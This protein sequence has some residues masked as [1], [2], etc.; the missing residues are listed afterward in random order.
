V[1]G[2]E[3]DVP[4]ASAERFRRWLTDPDSFDV[5]QPRPAASIMLLRDTSNGLEVFIL[6][7]V[8]GMKFLPTATVFPGGGV[9]ARD[10][11]DLPWAGPSPA[12]WAR[13]MGCD[14]LTAR[15]LIATAVRE[16]FEEVGVLLA[17]PSSNEL[18]TGSVAEQWGPERAALESHDISLTE[19]LTAQNLV[20]R[21]D[22]LAFRSR[23]ITP[24]TEPSRFNTHFF[25]AA[26]PPG[27]VAEALTTEAD[28]FRWTDPQWPIDEARAGRQLVVAPTEANLEELVT[29]GNVAAAMRVP[30]HIE[31]IMMEP[32][33]RPDGNVGM[34]A[35][36]PY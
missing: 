5:V 18:V 10:N 7:R 16:L 31:P 29:A 1:I 34:R 36:R 12:E 19:F 23:W 8:T 33:W 15:Q 13:R 28:Q 17:G 27:Q 4:K 9:D 20:L 35:G 2:R 11:E 32:F 6:R 3:F 25:A 24:P 22:L 14:E 26:L 30:G 21:S